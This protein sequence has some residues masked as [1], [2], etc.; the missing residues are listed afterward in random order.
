M[1][2]D[3]IPV[4]PSDPFAPPVLGTVTVIGMGIA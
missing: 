3:G 2:L 4:D 1:N